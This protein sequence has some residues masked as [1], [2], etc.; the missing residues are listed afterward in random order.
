MCATL[1]VRTVDV[2]D[3]EGRPKIAKHAPKHAAD[4][5]ADKGDAVFVAKI[6][7]ADSLCQC[8]VRQH[9]HLV[10]VVVTRCVGDR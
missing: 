1:R 5:G 8:N 3:G 4:V 9:D 6:V 10:R 7:D 2:E